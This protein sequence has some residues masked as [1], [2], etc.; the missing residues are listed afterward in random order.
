MSGPRAP[1]RPA[2][3]QHAPASGVGMVA[4]DEITGRPGRDRLM[5]RPTTGRS[6]TGTPHRAMGATTRDAL[7]DTKIAYTYVH[8]VGF[9]SYCN[10]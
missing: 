4:P 7:K 5:G 1:F 2:L 3:P 8:T 9:V 6:S 10:L